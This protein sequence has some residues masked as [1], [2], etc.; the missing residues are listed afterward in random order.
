M[1][2]KETETAETITLLFG[3]PVDDKHPGNPKFA[4]EAV[5]QTDLKSWLNKKF[6]NYPDAKPDMAFSN[7]L[8]MTE[9]PCIDTHGNI[10]W[11]YRCELVLQKKTVV[12]EAVKAVKAKK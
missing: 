7:Y 12:K 9:V 4:A 1:I 10:Y 2:I 11:E 6:P 5:Y 3:S 8:G